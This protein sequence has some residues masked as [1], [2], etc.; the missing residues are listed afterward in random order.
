MFFCLGVLGMKFEVWEMKNNCQ[1]G[2]MNLGRFLTCR[3]RLIKS[4][5]CCQK[6]LLEQGDVCATSWRC[7]K[8][9]SV[10]EFSR[11]AGVLAVCGHVW[12]L[13]TSFFLV[14]DCCMKKDIYIC[15]CQ[16]WF[17]DIFGD[18]ICSPLDSNTGCF[19]HAIELTVTLKCYSVDCMADMAGGETWQQARLLQMQRGWPIF[20]RFAA[21]KCIP[22]VKDG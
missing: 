9:S 17:F 14:I 1:I 6:L 7:R 3:L 20:V 4:K 21:G 13:K 11:C 16:T 19:Y 22:Y 8:K 2:M 15:N 10:K 12:C 5:C 18:S